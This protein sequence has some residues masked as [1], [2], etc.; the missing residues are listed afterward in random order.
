MEPEG[1]LPCSQEPSMGPYP[2]RDESI[3]YHP[4]LYLYGPFQYYP[5]TYV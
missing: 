3:P 1:S 2:R 4:I 5:H